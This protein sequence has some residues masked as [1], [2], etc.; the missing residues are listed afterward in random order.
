MSTVQNK[1][2]LFLQRGLLLLHYVS[3]QC[4]LGSTV[5]LHS[6]I[7]A[8]VEAELDEIISSAPISTLILKWICKSIYF[9]RAYS[10][11]S[12]FGAVA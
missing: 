8:S 11:V 1:S 5:F 9:S 3:L 4:L 2:V 10:Y 7:R 6:I 12:E